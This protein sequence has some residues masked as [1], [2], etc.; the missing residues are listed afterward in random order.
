MNDLEVTLGVGPSLTSTPVKEHSLMN[1]PSGVSH[2]D[3]GRE[4][5]VERERGRATRIER[6]KWG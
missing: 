2:R 3:R 1:L 4:E 5:V 6:K